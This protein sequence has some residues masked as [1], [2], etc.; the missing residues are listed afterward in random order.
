GGALGLLREV[1]GD[2][3]M[4]VATLKAV[5]SLKPG[6]FVLREFE[7]LVEELAAG[8]YGAE[9]LAPHLL[10]GLHLAGNLV[11]PF[12]RHMAVRAGSPHTRAVREVDGSRQLLI[13]VGLHLMARDAELLRVR[14]F[15]G[16]VERAPEDDAAKEASKRQE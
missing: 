5:V 14:H 3:G 8:V 15:E 12:M 9:D 2:G 7:S 4:A 1:H 13:H 16:G 6:P 10:R 11:G